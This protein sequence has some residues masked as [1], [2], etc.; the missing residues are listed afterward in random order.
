M[1]RVGGAG[2]VVSKLYIKVFSVETVTAVSLPA[3]RAAAPCAVYRDMA[4]GI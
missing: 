1:E 2:A 4:A 3:A